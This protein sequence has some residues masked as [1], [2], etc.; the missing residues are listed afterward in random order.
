MPLLSF[1][2]LS[3]NYVLNLGGKNYILDSWNENLQQDVNDKSFIQGDIGNRIV[4][5]NNR[6]HQA[7][8][9]GS[10]LILKDIDQPSAPEVNT[11]NVPSE[12]APTNIYDVFDLILENLAV[13]SKPIGIDNVEY[14]YILDNATIN[15]N[16]S[17]TNATA[18]ITSTQAD[19]FGKVLNVIDS[20]STANI[21]FGETRFIGRTVKYWDFRLRLFGDYLALTQANI[22]IRVLTE[23][24][25]YVGN[26]YSNGNENPDY[27][28]LGYQITGD[29]TVSLMDYQYENFKLYQA[30]GTFG[31]FQNKIFLALQN[32]YRGDRTLDFG[33]FLV[34]P[35][36]EFDTGASKLITARISFNTFIRSSQNLVV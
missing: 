11:N 19:G 29:A 34:P 14:P 13:V 21:I 2:L 36:I 17:D 20:E 27:V 9:S 4:D 1:E 33:E 5:I 32:D 8:M 25:F 31:V 23:K 3:N 6:T 26:N 30:P 10:L 12:I 28:I 15:L 7:T 18:T 35:R 16:F 24:K 22:S